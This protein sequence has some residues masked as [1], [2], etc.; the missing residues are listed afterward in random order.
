MQ[1]FQQYADTM[2]KMY[3]DAIAATDAMQKAAAEDRE[4]ATEELDAAQK[5]REIAEVS[6]E[7]MALEYFARKQQKLV[8]STRNETLGK[9][10]LRLLSLG[11]EVPEIIELLETTEAFIQPYQR[12]HL[13]RKALLEKPRLEYWQEGRGGTVNYIAGETTIKFDWEFGGGDA[14]ALIFVP[15]E[16]YWEAQTKTPLSQREAILEFTAQQVVEDKAPG[17]FYSISGGILEILYTDPA[18]KKKQKKKK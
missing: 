14:V 16:Q 3:A 17:C 12:V 4:K 11:K 1:D 18:K 6:G 13:K 9:I 7:E 10:V 8:E 5:E 15:E 2:Q